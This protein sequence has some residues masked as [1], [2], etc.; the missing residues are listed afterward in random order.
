LFLGELN[1]AQ[2]R[3]VRQ[4]LAKNSFSRILAAYDG[5][6]D[7]LKAVRRASALSS[8]FGASLVVVHVY[9]LP[10]VVYGGPGPMPLVDFK[11]LEDSAEAKA[12][13][14]LA[15]G[16]EVCKQEGVQVKAQLLESASVVQ[17]ILEFAQK[18]G[19]DLIVM[20]TRGMTGFKKLLLGSVSSG[21]VTHAHCSVLVVR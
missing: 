18:E 17:A 9:S 6:P 14:T 3:Q 19:V 10:S 2:F 8:E 11:G 16:V 21:V 7:S 4:G 13:D 12:K 1:N 5:S 15:K 20:G